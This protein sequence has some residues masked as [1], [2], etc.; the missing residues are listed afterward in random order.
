MMM[1]KHI[2]NQLT[3]NITY[4]DRAIELFNSFENFLY[5]SINNAY[6]F[7]VADSSK[8][9]NSNLKLYDA[10]L[11]ASETYSSTILDANYNL[12]AS[13]PDLVFNQ[14]IMNLTSFYAFEN[15]EYYYNLSID[16]YVP[17]TTRHNITDVDINYIF[18]YPNGTFLSQFEHQ[19]INPAESHTLLY[20]IEETLPIGEGYY[21][22]IWANK[23]YFNIANTLKH[24]NVNSGLINETIEGLISFLYQG[25]LLNITLPINYTRRDN[26]IL[27]AS[28]EGKDIINFTAQEVNFTATTELE[29]FT[30][31]DFN[32]TARPGA[33]PGPSEIIFKITKG[34][35]L[36]LEIKKIIE[37]G[38]SFDFEHLLYQSKVV[39]GENIDVFL[40]LINYLPNATQSLNVSFTGITENSI[41]SYIQEE[42]LDEKESRL[43]SYNLKTLENIENN[44]IRI[45]MN[46]IQNTTIYY[47]EELTI[48]IIPKFEIISVSFPNKISQGAPAYFIAIIKNNLEN[49]EVF[50]LHINGKLV[51]SN[52]NE[53]IPGENRI[54]KKIIPTNNPYDFGTKIYRVILEDSENEEIARFYFEVALELSTFNLL[55]FYLVPV[56]IPIGIMLYFLHKQIK[57]K[58]LRR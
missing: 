38:Y 2:V 6:D 49:S 58:K 25:P 1:E 37:I 39:S 21:I 18:K 14:D 30:Y 52:I 34:N 5:D 20:T 4:Y 27:T 33:I 11:K 56:I 45:E 50:S 26:L 12:T 55:I 46:I 3:G 24:F 17:F 48:E 53:L 32:L 22:Y 54:E 44:I 43:V 13:V 36:Y 31:I 51:Q 23:T 41:E 8:N 35:I 15:T 28:L 42:T 47:T 57:H 29:E 16:S 10:Y 9:F 40:D 7:S 19:I